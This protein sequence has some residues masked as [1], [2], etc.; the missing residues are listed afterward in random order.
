[1][2]RMEQRVLIVGSDVPG[3]LEDSYKKAFQNIGWKAFSWSPSEALKRVA[4]VPP[5]GG[6]FSSFVHVE[7]WERKANLELLS[8]AASLN[9]GLIL[10]ITTHGVQ[11]GTLAQLRVLNPE[12][13]IYCIFPDSPHYLD[14]PRINCLPF[15][16]RVMTSS[17]A[18]VAAFQRLG[19]ERVHYLPFAAD[20]ELHF[21]C[22][23]TGPS[24]FSSHDVVFIGN[25]R[26]ERE[27]LLND[28][29]DFDLFVWGTDYWKSRTQPGSPLR[30]RWGGRPV[31]GKEFSQVC[32]QS[33][34]LLNIMDPVT[35]PGPNMRTFEQPACRAFSLVTRSPAVTDL[36]SEGENIEC[37]S[38]EEEARDKI[39]FY[40]DNESARRRIA[41]AS[42]EFVVRRGHTY[43]DRAKQLITW[44]ETDCD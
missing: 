34:V 3:R 41:D 26:P 19:A 32:S 40:L 21:P 23:G 15:F 28:L 2:I 7:T 30:S 17:P 29:I 37:Y 8:I 4:R 27:A 31:E 22:N 9:P 6:L 44:A 16:D 24:S 43:L 33:S 38:S 42:Y 11:A 1:L 18:W 14:T 36:F 5:I 20:T 10:V 13:I 25:W 39:R 35:W 12:A